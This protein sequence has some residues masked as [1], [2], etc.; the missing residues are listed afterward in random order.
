MTPRRAILAILAAVFVTVA[1]GAAA[2]AQTKCMPGQTSM[3]RKPPAGALAPGIC[4]LNTAVQAN[5]QLQVRDKNFC[6]SMLKYV[7]QKPAGRGCVY[8]DETGG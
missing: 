8:W 7:P 6:P 5:Q 3:P 4:V 1:G 2:N